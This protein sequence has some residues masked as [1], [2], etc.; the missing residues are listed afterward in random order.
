MS[1]EERRKRAAEKKERKCKVKVKLV[2][3]F[4]C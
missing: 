2:I 3:S 4:E 1:F